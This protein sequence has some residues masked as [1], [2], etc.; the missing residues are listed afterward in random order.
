MVSDQ[1]WSIDFAELRARSKASAWREIETA[2]AATLFETPVAHFLV[3]GFLVDGIDKVMAHRT[4]IS[5]IGGGVICKSS[6]AIRAISSSGNHHPSRRELLPNGQNRMDYLM[7][8]AAIF[9]TTIASLSLMAPPAQAFG[10]VIALALQSGSQGG[11]ATFPTTRPRD[12]AA[13]AHSR[14]KSLVSKKI[15]CKKCAHP[16]GVKD[17][18]VARTVAAQVRQGEFDLKDNERQLVLF[19]LTKRFGI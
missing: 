18:A 11:S 14:G 5:P 12:P 9:A 2:L 16:G 8:N 13:E 15:G 4:A 3:R 17:A 7:R 19:Y 1:R 10:S 6:L